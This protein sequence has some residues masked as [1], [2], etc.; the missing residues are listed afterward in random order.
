MSGTTEAF[1]RVTIDAL[2][3]DVSW[4]LTDGSSVLFEYACPTAR[5][6]TM[7][8]ATGRAKPVL[9]M[10]FPSDRADSV[11]PLPASALSVNGRG[12]SSYAMASAMRRA[13]CAAASCKAASSWWA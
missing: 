3:T 8:S 4:N 11:P 1:A 7:C 5:R 2:L 9:C 13:A 6:P 10:S 12:S